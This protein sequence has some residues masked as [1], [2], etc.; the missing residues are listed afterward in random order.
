MKLK[1]SSVVMMALLLLG[2]SSTSPTKK[3]LTMN[4][5]KDDT[6]NSNLNVGVIEFN[7]K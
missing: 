7:V 5:D 1:L 3:G 6:P 4:L 2:C